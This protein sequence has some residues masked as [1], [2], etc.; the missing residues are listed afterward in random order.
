[1]VKKGYK[2]TVEHRKKV[3]ETRRRNNSYIVIEETRRKMSEAKKG[4]YTGYK[5]PFYKHR[6]T[7]DTR[8]KISIAHIGKKASKDTRKKISESL[9]GYVR[10][11]EH[12]EKLN[13]SLSLWWKLNKNN[14]KVKERN[15]KVSKKLKIYYK[16]HK[17]PFYGKHHKKESIER[18]KINVSKALTGRIVSTKTRQKLSKAHKGKLSCNKGKTY[19]EM[20]GIDKALI[21][22]KEKAKSSRKT[23]LRLWKNPVYREKVIKNTLKSLRKR[24]T[25]YEQ[26]I[27]DLCKEHDLP[28]NY[29][30]DG[31][32]LIDY[33][34]PDFLSKNPK[35]I[36][37]TYTKWCH[38]INYEKIR[39]KRFIKFGYRTLFLGDNDLNRKDWAPICLNKI[40]KF[41]KNEN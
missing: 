20:Y 22:R 16:T 8:K 5:N 24:P 32:V 18:M 34:N 11:K 36:I 30:G 37:E 1:M 39:A 21:L 10:T 14:K 40:R 41:M 2:Q 29:V 23:A 17:S 3:V 35:L 9:I 19:E 27:I 38:P 13:L 31:K 28:F 25:S 33:A 12:Q 26:K 7:K 6:H 15:K 4:Q